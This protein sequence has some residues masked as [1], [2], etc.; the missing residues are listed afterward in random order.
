MKMIAASIVVASGS[1]LAAFGVI[2][3][4]KDRG[5]VALLFGLVLAAL[6]FLQLAVVTFAIRDRN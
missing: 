5:S 6:G 1:F 3:S 2:A 4:D